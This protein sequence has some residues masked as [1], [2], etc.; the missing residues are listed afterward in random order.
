M[1]IIECTKINSFTTA[2]ATDIQVRNMVW[3]AII[4]GATAI[5]YFPIS[6]NPFD[7]ENI[8]AAVKTEMINSNANILALTPTI[9]T[10][11]NPGTAV[12]AV[13]D[14]AQDFEFTWR[15]DANGDTWIFAAN[16]DMT[17]AAESITFTLPF[18]IS[19]NVPVYDEARN[20]TPSG[21]D[22]TDAFTDLAVHIYGPI[23]SA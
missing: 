10:A 8:S 19:G 17:P 9:L 6:F 5:G 12:T 2:E 13:E 14:T 3:H 11:E 7:F 16:M 23:V 4:R 15:Q 1:A 21:A 22:F 18:T 20:I